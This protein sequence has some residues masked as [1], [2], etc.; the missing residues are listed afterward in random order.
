MPGLLTLD[1]RLMQGVSTQHGSGQVGR[2][3]L[4]G[5]GIRRITPGKLFDPGK[6]FILS[7]KATLWAGLGACK[8]HLRVGTGAVLAGQVSRVGVRLR[9]ADISYRTSPPPNFN[10]AF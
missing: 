10:Y 6:P 8:S 7:T 1:E 3:S 5:G 2:P 9:R 4:A